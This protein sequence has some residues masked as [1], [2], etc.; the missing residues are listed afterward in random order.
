MTSKSEYLQ[1]RGYKVVE[2]IAKGAF[3][4]VFKAVYLPNGSLC[5][6]KIINNQQQTAEMKKCTER[7]IDALKRSDH[8]NIL[9][10]YDTFLTPNHTFIITALHD[11]DL[12]QYVEKNGIMTEHQAQVVTS[13][14]AQGIQFL[15]QQQIIHRDLKPANL[16]LSLRPGT[17]EIA[18]VVIADFG[19]ARE[20]AA[21]AMARWVIDTV[22]IKKKKV[23]SFCIIYLLV[24][25]QS[26]WVF[27]LI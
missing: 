27:F 1:H 9:K 19:F 21:K 11:T 20:L 12:K 5:A 17:K 23:H 10:L 2:R 4:K 15:W 25:G 22:T 7:E 8:P 16:L 18:L 14:V 13:Q 24:F 6:I 3:G 26:V